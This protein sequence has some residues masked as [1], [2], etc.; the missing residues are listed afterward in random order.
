MLIKIRN[1]TFE[2]N[3]SSTHTIAIGTANDFAEWKAG[4]K[5]FDRYGEKFVS[6]EEALGHIKVNDKDMAEYWDLETDN[7]KILWLSKWHNTPAD[8]LTTDDLAD[9]ERE[10]RQDCGYLAYREWLDW[11]GYLDTT[12]GDFVTPGGETVQYICAYGYDG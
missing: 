11:Y 1:N 5:Y 7:D 2:T 10:A 8:L 9:F 12:S 3:S 4:T 6:V